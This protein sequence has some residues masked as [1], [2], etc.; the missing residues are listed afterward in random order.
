MRLQA[1]ESTQC[2]SN[3]TAL[4]PGA[5][6]LTTLDTAKLF[7]AVVILPGV[8]GVPGVLHPPQLVKPQVAGGPVFNVAVWGVNPEDLDQ[9]NSL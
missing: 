7:D 8:V 3:M 2:Q 6:R 1:Q 9:I 5:V 4:R